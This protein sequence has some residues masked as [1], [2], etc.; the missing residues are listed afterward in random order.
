MGTR[1]HLR[2]SSQSRLAYQT[3]PLGSRSG[4]EA[5][6]SPNN[7]SSLTV[8]RSTMGSSSPRVLADQAIQPL[9]TLDRSGSG[10]VGWLRRPELESPV[11]S[12]AVVVLEVLAQ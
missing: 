2:R 1:R 9:S 5:G 8:Q 11:R 4:S 7:L 12:F 10:Q 3:S 6:S